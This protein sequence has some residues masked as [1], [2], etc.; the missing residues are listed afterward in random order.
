MRFG[1]SP[2]HTD[3]IASNLMNRKPPYD[4]PS[5]SDWV[6]LAQMAKA[7]A[8]RSIAEIDETTR[9]VA[10]SNAR[11]SAMEAKAQSLRTAR[12]GTGLFAPLHQR[13]LPS[14]PCPPNHPEDQHSQE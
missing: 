10:A 1:I 11:I 12:R 13:R 6:D 9:L 14:E 5:L 4:A 2:C 3:E 7:S 8:E